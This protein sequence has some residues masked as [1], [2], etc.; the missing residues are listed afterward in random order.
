[1]QAELMGVLKM[2]DQGGRGRPRKRIV[3]RASGLAVALGVTAFAITAHNDRNDDR[4]A[5]GPQRVAAASASPSESS[6]PSLSG[7]Y[8]DREA[9]T[10][11]PS[12]SLTPAEVAA[13]IRQQAAQHSRPVLRPLTPA[14]GVVAADDVHERSQKL[15]NGSLR[16]VTARGDLTGQNVLLWAA[17]SGKV[18]GHV[19]CTQD[20]K[21]A[22]NAVPG[23]RPNLL[24]CWRT[25]A[26]RSVA[27]VLVDYGGHPS[28]RKSR[29]VIA[30]EWARLH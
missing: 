13:S 16:V 20:V 14:P 24:L 2:T 25:S 26:T 8:A 5:A 30:R 22:N 19:A 23:V 3:L 15:P 6:S 11:T 12:H 21:F 17:D 28:A 4:G 18:R 27:T 7:R 9:A 1:M 10:P 29:K